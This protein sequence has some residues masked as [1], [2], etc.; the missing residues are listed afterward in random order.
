M[1]ALRIIG[2]AV[3]SAGLLAPC[4]SA[5]ADQQ[6][7]Q[8]IGDWLTREKDGVVR[9]RQAGPAELTATA[10]TAT[11]T[12]TSTGRPG[13]TLPPMRVEGSIVAGPG[14]TR[15]D[16]KNP[17]PALRTRPLLGATILHDFHY[18]GGGKWSGGLI[19][20]PDNGKTYRCQLTLKDAD[21]LEVRGYI[22]TPLLGRTETWT[23]QGG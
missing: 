16:D 10:V 13:A 11:A 3:L 20:D 14:P 12:A 21:T 9:I 1:K 23:R 4:A 2:L 22:G 15:K 6:E 19:Y 5:W 8:I 7:R 17:D 18:D